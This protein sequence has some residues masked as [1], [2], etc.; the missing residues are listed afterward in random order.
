MKTEEQI[1]AAITQIEEYWKENNVKWD[2]EN[3]GQRD[4][5]LWVIDDPNEGGIYL[6]FSDEEEK[7]NAIPDNVVR[8]P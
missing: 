1:R 3:A 6:D 4:A 7:D 5:L 8:L 2:E